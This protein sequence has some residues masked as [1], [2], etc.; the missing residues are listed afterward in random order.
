MTDPDHNDPT[1]RLQRD[2]CSKYGS[3]TVFPDAASKL[4]IALATLQRI[5]ITA[6]RIH[7]E[8]GTNGWYIHGGEYSDDADFYQPLHTSHLAELLPQ[9][10]PYLALAPGY[11]FIIDDEG[12]EDVWYDPNVLAGR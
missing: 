2:I 6:C 10:L 5:P 7:P 11:R 3:P 12:Y 8:N 1:T 9:V 4:G